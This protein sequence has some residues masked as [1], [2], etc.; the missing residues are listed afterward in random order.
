MYEELYEQ[1]K[2]ALHAIAW[3]YRRLCEQDRAVDVDDLIQAA[4]IGLVKAF[5]V[6]DKNS[7]K[8]W[9]LCKRGF[10]IAEIHALLGIRNEKR[11]NPNSMAISLDAPISRD[12][13][14][15]TSIGDM[16]ADDSLPELD[17]ALLKNEIRQNVRESINRISDPRQRQALMLHGIEGCDLS[18][19]ASR[20]GVSTS[21][22]RCIFNRGMSNLARDNQL[23][24]LTDLDDRTRFHAHKGVRAFLSD[25]TSVTEAAVLWRIEQ[26]DKIARQMRIGM[27]N[28]TGIYGD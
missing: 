17:E 6:F 4:F 16:L 21:H 27:P 8:S 13:D 7:G 22:A 1:N 10:I 2:K 14:N 25:R 24:A 5:Q 20:L 19:V 11:V 12:A 9:A 15:N 28:D 18:E 23:I 3:S 26:R